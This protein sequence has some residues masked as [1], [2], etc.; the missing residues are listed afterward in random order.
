MTPVFRV[1]TISEKNIQFWQYDYDETEDE[2][3]LRFKRL[4]Q[5]E[6]RLQIIIGCNIKKGLQ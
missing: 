6:Q 1:E 5:T 4:N 3:E 2:A